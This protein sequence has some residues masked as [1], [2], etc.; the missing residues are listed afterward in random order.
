MQFL[1]PDPQCLTPFALER[2]Y[3]AGPEGTPWECRVT[4]A[5]GVLTVQR[6]A[7]ESGHLYF[8]WET[9]EGLVTLNTSTLMERARPYHLSVELARGTITRLRNQAA[10]WELAGMNIPE[11]F[12]KTLATASSSFGRAA[13]SQANAEV[14][15]REATNTL[16]HACAAL[17][18]LGSSY[19]DQVLKLRTSTNAS[20][21]TLLGLRVATVPNSTSATWRMQAASNTVFVEPLWSKIE[22]NMGQRDWSATDNVV[23]WGLENGLRLAMGPMVRLDKRNLPD[24]ITLWND[25]FEELASCVMQ[26]VR[27]V[28]QRYKGKV[29]LWHVTA[30]LNSPDALSLNEN[31]RL[32]L[33][34]EAVELVRSLDQR[35]PVVVS[36]NQPWGEYIAA[37][38]HELTP[39]TYADTLVRSDLGIS[40]IGLEINLGCWPGGTLP[41]DILEISRTLDRWG[42]LGLPLI[43]MLSAAGAGQPELANT[44]LPEAQEAVLKWLLPLLLAKQPV[45]GIVWTQLV[46]ELHQEFPGAGLFDNSLGAKP[47]LEVLSK[48]REQYLS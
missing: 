21:S 43:V 1:I 4:A 7:R 35:T 17:R 22:T 38:D 42:Q 8:P 9:T 24:W 36:V 23:R 33:T 31:Q 15:H 32:R 40:G 47:A 34:V 18:Q 41:R 28:V 30:G 16:Q 29:Q 14:A 3:L 13:T 46:D 25:D 27:A 37:E 10:A 6:G 45:Q 39:F 19:V 44:S 26:Q 48:V 20:L 5:D 12:R 2:A 11:E